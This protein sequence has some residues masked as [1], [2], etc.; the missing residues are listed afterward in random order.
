MVR[1]R[2]RDWNLLHKSVVAFIAAV[3]ISL[4]FRAFIVI[5]AAFQTEQEIIL[6]YDSAVIWP[7][8]TD[9]QNRARWQAELIDLQ[10]LMGVADTPGSTRLLFWKKRYKR[11]QAVEQTSEVVQERLFATLQESDGDQRWFRVELTPLGQCQTRVV[12]RE[13]IRP[14]AYTDRF[15]FFRYSGD[16]ADR[17]KVSLAALDRWLGKVAP[18]CEATP[19]TSG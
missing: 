18:A 6:P 4:S 11:W 14:L 10:R 8:V 1:D 9:N 5:D 15:W 7:W 3:A 12:I 13:T 19:V 2:F 16:H 17:L